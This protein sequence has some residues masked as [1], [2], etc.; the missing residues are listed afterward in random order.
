MTAPKRVALY[1]RVST[2]DQSLDPQLDELRRLADHRGW[3]VIGEFVDL[4]ISGTKDRRPALDEMIKAT[5]Q[6]RV[7]VVAV[8]A[9]DRF[10]RSVRHL[11][12]ALEDFRSRNVD[13]VSSRDAIDTTSVAGRFTF[14]VIAAVAEMERELIR[15]RTMAGLAS[16]RRKG[17]LLGRRPAKVDEQEMMDLKESGLSIRKIAI[18]LGISKSF[19]CKRLATVHKSPLEIDAA[20]P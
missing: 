3:Q 7:D 16:A 9:F 12:L 15:Q 20:D 8:V 11:V 6:G 2:A 14:H 17:R 10:A 4:G 18:Q 1:A 19:V 13:F 5:H